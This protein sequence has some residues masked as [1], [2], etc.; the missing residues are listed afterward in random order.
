M[1]VKV[2][3]VFIDKVTRELYSPGKMI[4][5]SGEERIEDL[6]KRG[7]IEPVKVEKAEAEDKPK[8]QPKKDAVKKVAKK[9]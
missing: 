2:K 6:V 5:I 3:S 4:E 7:L 8:A 9:K 1:K